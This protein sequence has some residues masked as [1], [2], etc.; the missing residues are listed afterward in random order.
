MRASALVGP[1][2]SGDHHRVTD[3][4]TK[5]LAWGLVAL[6]V[7]SL[8][9]GLGLHAT[10]DPGLEPS[11]AFSIAL[12]AALVPVGVLVTRRQPGN[13]IGWMFLFVALTFDLGVLTGGYAEYWTSGEGGS[14]GLGKAAAWYASSSWTPW[15][16]IPA[17]FL[18][19]LFPD[20]KL[21]PGNRWR[22]AAWSAGVGIALTWVAELLLPGKLEDYPRVKNPYGVESGLVE[23]LQGLGFLLVAI[24]LVGSIAAV[25][26]RFR[27]GDREQREQIKWI[28]LAGAVIAVIVPVGIATY[29]LVGEDVANTAIE[30]SIL[31]LPIAAGVAMLRYRLYDVD[32]VINRTLVYATLTAGLAAVYAVVALGLGV[33]IGSGST[34]PTA[35]ATLAVALLFRPLRGRVQTEVDR[36][37]DRAR[38]EG[39]RTIE[40]F[41]AEL[42]AGRAAPERAGSVLAEA[43]GDP[44]LELLFWL[45]A[46]EVH[47][48]ATGRTVTRPDAPGQAK[49][50]VRRG[51]L[52][53]ATVVHDEALDR[54]P[55]LLDSVLAAAG[56]AIE[57]GRLRAEV[58]RRLAE[59]EDSR[60]RIVTAGFEERRRLERDL[61]DGAQQR[62]VSIG[63]ALRHV[64]SRLPESGAEA[65]EL[66][67]S[68]T[69]LGQAIDELRELARGVRP[70]GLD[71]GLATALQALASRSP[72]RTRVDA[73]D[74][75]FD[76]R[77]ETA[78]YFVAS[79]ALTNAVK[80]AR[81][82]TVSVSAA[83][84]DGRLLVSIRDDGVGGASATGGSGIVG[85]S[86][87]VSALGGRLSV[88]SPP[89]G[90]TMV[91]AELPC[92]S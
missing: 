29:D 87:R 85:M 51:E 86:D 52:Q 36:R 62:L 33:A 34:V 27:R 64:Q 16:L 84:Q 50:P 53:L 7:G 75:R 23:P 3:P 92:E 83:R 65:R 11:T 22:L 28:A 77:L 89:G 55:N 48:D 76:D 39:L 71:D 60:T 1:P 9:C 59:V 63:L 18:L 8:A 56:L 31:G 14:E 12:T 80:H 69:E 74:E 20:G 10:G 35:A 25:I 57:I 91:T 32:V 47:T 67:A 38:Y 79:E 58:R 45:P 49:T 37:F 72:L 40:R 78:A 88:D 21:L 81:A 24:G 5:R 43:L 26:L 70:A 44:N 30:L 90:G 61:H 15:V 13:P 54:R 4:A 68:V 6:C 46:E 2:G 19:L 42:R 82:S 73:T 41:L 17:T 66:D